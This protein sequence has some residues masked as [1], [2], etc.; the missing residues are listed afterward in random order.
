M[1]HFAKLNENNEVIEVIVVNNN[2]IDNLDFPDSEPKGVLFCKFL[3]GTETNWKQTSYNNS[4]RKNFAGTGSLYNTDNDIFI[5][6]KLYPSWI[7]NDDFEWEPPIP[8]PE[9][10]LE[11]YW[12]ED[13][14]QWILIE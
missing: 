6:P 9:D 14:Q 5:N 11:Y 13:N 10:G 12:N 4:F 7:L 8:Y 2:V 3:Y 1:A